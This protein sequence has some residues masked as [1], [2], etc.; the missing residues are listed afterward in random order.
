M[1]WND[2]DPCCL[3]AKAD[4]GLGVLTLSLQSLARKDLRSGSSRR[5]W[6]SLWEISFHLDSYPTHLSIHPPAPEL[7]QNIID[8]KAELFGPEF[9]LVQ[10]GL[11]SW[12]RP[13]L[14]E[15]CK[16]GNPW[17]WYFPPGAGVLVLMRG[18]W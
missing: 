1:G 2:S 11:N 6:P 3:R 15:V 5:P 13:V 17:D 4:L 14:R 9:C 16:L 8:H 10:E 18:A 12:A 7:P